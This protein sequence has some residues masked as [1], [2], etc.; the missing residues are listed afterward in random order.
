MVV[1]KCCGISGRRKKKPGV[2]IQPAKNEVEN[3]EDESSSEETESSTSEESDS[4]EFSEDE[5]SRSHSTHI[6]PE[7]ANQDAKYIVGR[8]VCG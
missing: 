2:V 3:T 5:P 7:Y 6:I 1:G 8:L 4:D